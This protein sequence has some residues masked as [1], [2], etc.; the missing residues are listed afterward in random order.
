MA[1]IA[2][3]ATSVANNPHSSSVPVEA[4]ILVD[5]LVEHYLV[6]PSAQVRILRIVDETGSATVGEI[7]D[8]LPEHPDPVA[9]IAVMLR[10]GILVAELRGVLDAN[11]V[12][13]RAD[14]EPDPTGAACL[15]PGPPTPIL[16]KVPAVAKDEDRPM[17]LERLE[18]TPFSASVIVGAGRDRRQFVRMGEL[19]RPGIYGLMNAD[20]VYIGMGSDVALRVSTGHQPINDIDAI[21]VITDSNGEL[22]SGDAKVAERNLWSRAAVFGDR[23]LVNG[24]PDGAP[25]DAQRYS[26]IDQFV[27]S[28]SLAL[29]HHDLLF[30]RGSARGLIAGPRAEP[31]RMAPLRRMNDIPEGEILELTFNDGRVALAAKQGD[32]RWLLLRGSDVRIDTVATAGAGARFQR[33]AWLHSGLLDIGADGESYVVTRDLVFSSG[34]AVAH[35]CTGSKG[36]G[37]A[38]WRP[39]DPDGG[40][41]HET[42]ALIAR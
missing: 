40:Y 15:P 10:L 3:S 41:D 9:A 23:T 25:V 1:D 14:P 31:G 32:D 39:I 30:T 36:K 34:S 20:A 13:R 12:V 8:A 37:L 29:R 7:V 35:F 33:S 19:H 42:A 38:G 27:A 11:T 24:L 17:H 2:S 4:P 5:G 21:F 6:S 16:P 28:A 18:V 22:G 26:E